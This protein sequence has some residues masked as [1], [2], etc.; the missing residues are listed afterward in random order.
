MISRLARRRIFLA[1]IGA[2][3][4]GA[5]CAPPIQSGG[6][7]VRAGAAERLGMVC[8]WRHGTT[9]GEG[10]CGEAD[11]PVLPARV[12]RIAGPADALAGPLAAG[13]VGDLV[14]E[15]GE[16]AVVIDQLG[17]GSGFAE[18]GGN[19][20]DAADARTRHDELGQIFTYFGVFPRQAVHDALDSGVD[21]KGTAWIEARGHEL[22]EE[23]LR[24]T[25]RYEL[26]PGQRALLIQTTLVNETAAPI[27][28]LDLGDVIQWG[29]A[30]KFAIG[31]EPGFVGDY[32]GPWIGAAGRSAAYALLDA[33]PRVTAGLTAKNG[34]AWSNV[35]FVRG[36]T[37]APGAKVSYA[38]V[39]V[40]APRGDTLGAATEVAF[41]QGVAPGG[42]EITLTDAAGARIAPPEGGRFS[43]TRVDPDPT[44]PS[45]LWLGVSAEAAKSGANAA[46]EAPPGRYLVTF[47]GAGRHEIAP[48]PVTLS[49]GH[50]A[51]IRLAV[52]DAGALRLALIERRAGATAASPGKIQI[53]AIDSGRRVVPPVLVGSDG[54]AEIPAAPGRYRVVASRGPEF[55]LAEQVI[56][57]ESGKASAATLT[58]DRVV[59]TRGFLGCD[60]HQHSAPSADSGVSTR[61]RVLS[62]AAEGVE[63]AV[64]SEHNLIVDLGA[65][66][67]EMKL[68]PFF[69]SI[70]GD[71]LTSDASREPFGHFNAFP[72]QVDASD[73]RGG[74]FPVRDR[75]AHQAMDAIRAAP[76]EH[77][78][79][80]NHPRTGR[81][82]YFD[83]YRFD[84]A[85]GV[86]AT[87]G[88][89]ARFD[90]VEVW[91]GRFVK[92]RSSVLDDLFALLRTSHPVTPTANTDTHGIFG[93]EAGYPRTYVKV[94]DDD[95]A[96]LD[97]AELVAGLRTRRDVVLT[98][99]PFVTVRVGEV[100]Q[101]GLVTLPKQG[102]T[103]SIHVERAPWIDV[104]ELSLRV[105]G[106]VQTVP[107][108]GKPGPTG[109]LI[110]DVE[111]RLVRPGRTAEPG[112]H[113]LRAVVTEDTFVMVEVHGQ[114]PLEPVLTGDPTEILPFAITAPLWI[115]ADGDGQS[116]GRGR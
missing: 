114:K 68:D 33:D 11:E 22:Y 110:D 101:G 5:A 83:Q 109:A 77:V 7:E 92:A 28:G 70:V 107:L 103:L 13:R 66:V 76:G 113:G 61:E 45:P 38:R 4:A 65:I 1:S 52:S 19:I 75:T 26:A 116:L 79:Q 37:I 56:T 87:A 64:A 62:N 48:A 97:P 60:L 41:L 49:A 108:A 12:K 40:V 44:A 51:A 34:T 43:L 88:Y 98:N 31:K 25:T 20:V 17:R 55:A 8:R 104:T 96:R 58:L 57:V 100:E 14:I 73:A 84:P 16:I 2:V 24:V 63:C 53:F 102:A 82:G 72:L 3:A 30:E 27:A 39:L 50:T 35:S 15:N 46:A 9:A 18:S 32:A 91:S 36:V 10:L 71:E 78:I 93:Q 95:P 23:H 6:V 90:A 112:A 99:G 105:G 111:A 80:V 29:S 94:A 21:S 59:D 54:L 89:D 74:A 106:V 86:G 85:L 81:T 42:L 67:R 69:R 47:S 115:D